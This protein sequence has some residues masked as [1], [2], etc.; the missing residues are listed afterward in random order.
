MMSGSNIHF[1]M[2][3]RDR[4]INYGGIGAI[5]LMGQRLGLAQE[6]DSRLQLLK[7][8]LPYHESDHVLNLAY[9]ALLDGQRLEDIEL[10]RNDEAFLDGLGAQR[11]PDPT[12]SGDF[13]RRFDQDSLLTLMEAINATR[14]QV[15]E[16]Q[17]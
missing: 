1:E 14:Q 16:K 10:R 5:H 2:A 11:I 7:R 8:H 17:P 3:E 12:T 13:T 9:N 6:I 4:A 15:W